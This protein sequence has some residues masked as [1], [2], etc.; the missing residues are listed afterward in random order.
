MNELLHD[1]GDLNENYIIK[2]VHYHFEADQYD[3]LNIY[4]NG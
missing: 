4:I 1:I 2:V 3:I